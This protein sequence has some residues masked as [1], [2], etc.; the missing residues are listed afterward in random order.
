MYTLNENVT[1]PPAILQQECKGS[2]SSGGGTHGYMLQEVLL[3][4][5]RH[6]GTKQLIY[7]FTCQW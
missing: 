3:I 6:H 7:K 1:G 2:Y 5:N 4:I